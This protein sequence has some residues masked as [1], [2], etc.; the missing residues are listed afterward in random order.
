M[1]EEA[2]QE[3]A[4]SLHMMH[5][6]GTFLEDIQ[7]VGNKLARRLEEYVNPL[8]F[9]MTRMKHPNVQKFLCNLP[10]DGYF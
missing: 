2:V 3:F 10:V 7:C 6:T 4:I 8:L 1:D 9:P 5:V